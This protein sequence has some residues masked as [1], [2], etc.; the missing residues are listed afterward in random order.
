MTTLS[1]PTTETTAPRSRLNRLWQTNWPLTLIG[2]GSV[3]LLAFA[4]V[5][6][7]A[8]PRLI[9]GQV[10]WVKPMKFA[11]SITFYSLTLAWMLGYVKGH[12]RLVG[13]VGGVTATGFVIELALIVMQVVRGVRSHFNFTTPFDGAVFSTM[14]S[15]ILVVWLMTL[16]AA[17]LVVRQKFTDAAFAWSLRLGLLVSAVGMVVAFLMTSPTPS[18]AAEIQSGSMPAE[19]GAHSV[20]VQD[21][22]P[23]LPF[24]GWS[25]EGGD[26]RIPHFVGLH[27]L[28]VLPL[29][30]FAINRL[31]AEKLSQRRRAALVWTLGLGYLGFVVLLTWQALRGQSIVAPDALTL[32]AFGGLFVAVA[33]IGALI[34]AGR[35]AQSN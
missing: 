32:A 3:A 4:A 23:G 26:L 24:V 30:G 18:Q 20:G 11:I 28:Q 9:T 21:G 27:A 8:D 19:I 31:F 6:A 13:L 29:A 5:M 35:K 1:Y 22:G 17:L 25:T 14:G 16:V 12:P 7:V 10:A 34:V 2:L 33:A 15:T